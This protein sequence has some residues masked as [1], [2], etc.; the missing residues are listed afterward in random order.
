MGMFSERNHAL[1]LFSLFFWTVHCTCS[2][3][4]RLRSDSQST[5]VLILPGSMSLLL[6]KMKNGMG[7]PDCHVTIFDIFRGDVAQWLERRNA[8]PKTMHWFR[9]PGGAG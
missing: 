8:N 2:A 3:L 5:P 9:L 1:S 4:S 7:S 6:K